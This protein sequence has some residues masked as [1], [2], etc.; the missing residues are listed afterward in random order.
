MN[1]PN[2]GGE[3]KVVDSRPQEDGVQRRRECLE[4]KERFK[5]VEI[6]SELYQKLLYAPTKA[7]IVYKSIGKL[8][9]AIRT[10]ESMK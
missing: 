9:D 2:C 8:M 4:C 6:D 10:L 5:T 7:E 3:T 1:C